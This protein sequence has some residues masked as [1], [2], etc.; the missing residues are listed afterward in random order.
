MAKGLAVPP[1]GASSAQHAAIFT[2]CAALAGICSAGSGLGALLFKF[3]LLEALGPKALKVGHFHYISIYIG[4]V[5]LLIGSIAAW[6]SSFSFL[7]LSGPL[8]SSFPP[9]SVC[10]CTDGLVVVVANI[11]A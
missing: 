9:L 7:S 5:Y 4:L 11:P 8:P 3:T 6:A 1:G 10:Y 2:F